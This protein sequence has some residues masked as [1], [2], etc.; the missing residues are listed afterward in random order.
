MVWK[1]S[2]TITSGGIKLNIIKI[3]TVNAEFLHH[4]LRKDTPKDPWNA[5]HLQAKKN[6]SLLKRKQ[7]Q[8]VYAESMKFHKDVPPD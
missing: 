5:N 3:T 4:I 1:S 6:K 7:M 2:S 8:S